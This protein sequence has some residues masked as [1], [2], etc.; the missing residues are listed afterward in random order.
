MLLSGCPLLLTFDATLQE[1]IEHTLGQRCENS[2]PT[3]VDDLVR[4]LETRIVSSSMVLQAGQVTELWG[5]AQPQ[6]S[7]VF[8]WMD[9]FADNHHSP[10][11]TS[12]A[13]WDATFGSA[14]G[15]IGTTLLVLT[16]WDDPSVVRRLWCACSLCA[17]WRSWHC[18]ACWR[19]LSAAK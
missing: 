10:P 7:E 12:R 5:E 4:A 3:S 6:P 1:G 14:V 9:V 11:P 18:T 2:V 17:S 16:P 15:D 13:D 8:A 19:C